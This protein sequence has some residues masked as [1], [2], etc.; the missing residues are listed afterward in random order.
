MDNSIFDFLNFDFN[1][2]A[3]KLD[4]LKVLA[5]DKYNDIKNNVKKY[6]L[7]TEEGYEAFI[8]EAAEVRTELL[9]SNSI[10]ANKLVE[11]LDSM[12]EKAM[13]NHTD[14]NANKPLKNDT[15]KVSNIIKNEVDRSIN[16]NHNKINT[17]KGVETKDNEVVEETNINWPSD[18]LTPR[19]KR[20]VWKLVDEYMDTMIVPYLDE[21]FDEDMVDDMA[22]G[23]F[24]F[25]AWILTKEE[26]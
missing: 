17:G 23:L 16:E 26:D 10:F 4:E 14:K 2:L 24:Q 22:N 1:D 20:N 5:T 8:K 25:A 13:K 3:K 21:E 19:Q 9:K 18:N 7:D 6:D 11:L 12:V 15:P